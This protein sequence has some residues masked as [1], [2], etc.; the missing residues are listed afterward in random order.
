M[1]NFDPKSV[2]SLGLLL[3]ASILTGCGGGGS[4]SS[5]GGNTG[6]NGGGSTDTSTQA[7][8]DSN[9]E[10]KGDYSSDITLTAGEAYAI[11]GEVNFLDGATLEIPAGTTLYGETQS[12]YLAINAGAM[13]MADGEENNPIIFTSAADFNG[14]STRDAQ[15]EWGGLTII[16]KAPIVGGTDVYEAGTQ[17]GGGDDPA[18]NSGVLDYVIIKHTGFEVEVDKELNGLSLLAVGSGTS[19]SNIGI[20]GGADDGIELWGGTVDVTNLY[21]YNAGDDSIDTDLGYTGTITNGVVV[22]K[23]VDATNYDSSGIE[24]GNDS[25]SY[26]SVSENGVIGESDLAA[27]TQATMPTFKDITIESVGGAIYL[28]NDAG[29]IFDNVKVTVKPSAVAGQTD[30]AGQAAVTHRTTDT[31]DDLSNN[32]WGVQILGGGIELKNEVTPEAV[33]ATATAKSDSEGGSIVED[34]IEAYWQSA[35]MN[36]A[37]DVFV[38]ASTLNDGTTDILDTVSP[39]TQ[40][41]PLSESTVTGANQSVFGWVLSEL[42]DVQ[43][44]VVNGDITTNTQWTKDTRY[45]LD[46]EINVLDGVTLDIEEGTT[47]FGL[48]QSSYLAVNRGAKI[49]AVGT[50]AEPIVFTSAADVAGD[51]NGEIVQG[52]WGGLTII[53]A[54]PIIGGTD[55]YEAGS[56]EG[57]GND[58]A[59]NSGNLAF[60]VIKNSGFEVEEDKELNGLSLL[61]VGNGTT[62]N[63]IAILGGSD[64]GIELWGGTVDVNGLFVYNAGDDSIDTDLGYTGTITNAYVRQYTVDATNYDS[65]GIENGNDSDSYTSVGGTNGVIGETTLA[66]NTQSTMPTFV[67]V[68]V[69]AVGGAIYLKND[70]GAIFDN[71]SVITREAQAPG[72]TSTTGQAVVT[73]RTTDQVDDLS[74]SPYGVQIL[75]GGLELINEVVPTDIY[76]I[77]TAKSD[78]EGGSDSATHI[79][80]YW[81]TDNPG[82]VAFEADDANVT[83]ATI[84][85]IWKGVAGTNDN[86]AVN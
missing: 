82:T 47:V 54:A 68:T 39:G 41:T 7:Y 85:D 34:H 58:A 74:G 10:L 13:I 5:D 3:T 40:F 55:I 67:N 81:T 38:S 78:L 14:S 27:N 83:G 77:E 15:G 75:S 66:N 21:V 32:P 71:V 36:G 52:Q 53:G 6:G 37:G 73:H 48:T 30:T 60:V 72:Q 65:S 86:T 1:Y 20:L 33:F 42:N 24:N 9:K 59:D 25:D 12:S 43:T 31:V 44:Q 46:G 57:G 2:G 50:Q 76:A 84:I 62:I 69:E 8:V 79:S 51:N 19:I 63:N 56:Q 22:Q 18:D 11:D 64:D 17:V 23:V 4:S 16:G 80:D 45:A 35:A 26:D 61:A 49:N 28:K 29:G 70:A